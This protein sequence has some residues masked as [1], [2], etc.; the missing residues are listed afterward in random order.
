MRHS[1]RIFQIRFTN[2]LLFHNKSTFTKRLSVELWYCDNYVCLGNLF[3]R[4]RMLIINSVLGHGSTG[5]IVVNIAR[6]YRQRG[7]EVTIAYGR[8]KACNVDDDFARMINVVRIG[9]NVDV[10]WHA[11]YTRLTDNHGLASK[12]ATRNFLQWADKYN[13]D[14]LWL[15]NIHGY[16]IHFELLFQWIKSRPNMKVKWTLHDCWAFTG[17]CT[18]FSFVRCDKWKSECYQCPQISQYPKSFK[19]CSRSN[20]FRKK[21]A[22][23]GIS[24]MTLVTPSN[25]L[26]NIVGKSFLS[27]YPVE[28]LYNE[29]NREVFRRTISSF[30]HDIGI[31]NKKMVLGV[32]SV[33]NDRK[34]FND[35]IE[36]SKLLDEEKYQIVLVGLHNTQI[37]E[38]KKK[39]INVIALPHVSNIQELVKIYSAADVY[40]NASYEE[41]F[42]L[43]TAE[44]QACGTYTIVYKDTAGEE[45]VDYENGTA[46]ESNVNLLCYEVVSYCER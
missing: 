26:K 29:V 18:H 9:N 42:G 15:H 22:F 3:V 16:Y 32:S 45:V 28:V 6:E 14:I 5:K 37:S 33:W 23:C 7:Y 2:R 4:M 25:W 11:L 13:P 17:H 46:I 40:I 35:F 43:T 10:Y 36:L 24:N 27:E 1:I 21:N 41:T 30:K 8:D 20:Y 44:A 39:K 12:K 19:D 38:L 31:L 34:G